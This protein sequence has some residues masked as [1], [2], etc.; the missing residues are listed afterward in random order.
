A[1]DISNDGFAETEVPVTV[2]SHEA[3]LTERVRLPG[4]TKT[5]HR[6]LVQGQPEEVILNDGTVPEVA[7]DIH[8]RDITNQ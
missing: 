4:K 3:T 5:V 2:R 7:A 1:I 6:M 8:Q